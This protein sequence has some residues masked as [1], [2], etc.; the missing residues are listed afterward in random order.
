MT[1]R[2]TAHTTVYTDTLSRR[3]GYSASDTFLT[4]LHYYWLVSYLKMAT[5]SIP[6]FLT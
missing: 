5:N 1:A 3:S 4:S 2:P 6:V